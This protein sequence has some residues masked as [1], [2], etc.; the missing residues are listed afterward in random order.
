TL[1]WGRNYV[2]RAQL[3]TGQGLVAVAVKLFRHEGG[4]KAKL[5]RDKARASWTM[6]RAFWMAGLPTAEPVLLGRSTRPKGPSIFVTRHLEE[7]VEARYLFRAQREG[8]LGE[9]F[10]GVD[11]EGFLNRV[12]A[13][14]RRMHEAGFW[15][16][17]LSIGNVLLRRRPQRRPPEDGGELFLIDLNRARHRRRLT[18]SER[19]RDLCR[20]AIFGAE[21]QEL[22]LRAYWGEELTSF[23]RWLYR[24]YHRGFLRK[25]ET[26]KKLRGGLAGVR[27]IFKV[28]RP[29]A[30][31]PPV[32]EGAGARDKIVWDPLS[33]QPHQHASRMEKTAVRLKDLA[34]HTA[35]A[36][37]VGGALP[38]IWRR[39][40]AL[41]R[42]LYSEPVP[43]L[44]LGVG[45]RPYGQAPEELL[46][47]LEGLAVRHVLLRLHP[48]QEEHCQEEELAR[49]LHARGYELTFSLP[50]NRDLVK[51]PA[52][53]RAGIE[54]IAAR[55]LPFGKSFQI[56]QAIN[57][58]KWGVWS[59]GEYERLVNEAAEALRR[60]PEARLLGPSVID[61][62]YHATAAVL[63]RRSS[64]ITFDA[65]AALLYVDR[66][67]APENRQSGF[68][69]VDK[70]TLLRA[71]AE[72]A[73][74][75]GEACWITE[76]NWPL[77]EG[78]HSPAGRDVSVDEE[79]Q[80]NFLVRYVLLAAATGL[81]ERM[82]WW[83]LVARGYGLTTP[84]E[85]GK[86]RRRPAYNALATLQRIL[87][88]AVFLRR[89]S[90]EE[91]AYLYRFRS[92]QGGDVLVGWTRSGESEIP[93]PQ[94]VGRVL[95]RDGYELLEEESA[96][97]PR[98]WKLEEAPVYFFGACD[99]SE[100][101]V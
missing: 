87:G 48:W 53:W 16:R 92:R 55:F 33:D 59:Y 98:T 20:L 5:R 54:E 27:E 67:G 25:I 17:D 94:P 14:L 19:T 60:D 47:A 89:E 81:V 90:V 46:E 78:P 28:R 13:L 44:N 63:N 31:I 75:S 32:P 86:L 49:E 23:R 39:Y 37:T 76:F 74:N 22:F 52:R 100:P 96:S 2:Y 35:T 72:T 11:F 84:E 68:D 66:R 69:A 80:A 4:L 97:A 85:G 42:G 99:P 82:Y 88:G 73:R 64:G 7:V 71:L 83:Q 8:R 95:S 24:R 57:R 79:S 12:G 34:G 93:L 36:L 101:A 65:V 1:H 38:R 91:P 70:V 45:L 51:D 3:E 29:H 62:E 26:K 15:H 50:Q 9:E 43:F 6:A 18:V 56:G 21:H 58:S 61:F 41:Q 40:R 10:P 77:W 30:H